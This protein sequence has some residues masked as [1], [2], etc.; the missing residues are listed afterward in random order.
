MKLSYEIVKCKIYTYIV[1]FFDKTKH[2]RKLK[3]F[4]DIHKGERCFI[5]GNGPSLTVD[6]LT[7]LH[8]NKE[9]T[10]ASNRIY[11]IFNKTEWRPTYYAS[12][13]R[14]I[15][16]NSQKE[17]EKI[18]CRAKF[19]PIVLHWYN[20][21]NIKDVY[22]YHHEHRIDDPSIDYEVSEDISK[23][24]LFKGTVTATMMQLA[25]YMG[26]TEIYLIGID[27]NY[28]ITKGNDGKFV[29]H[30]DVVDYFS[31]KYEVGIEKQLAHNLELS[32]KSYKDL[33]EYADENNIKVINATR[34]GK[35][36]VYPRKALEE[37]L[38]EE[39]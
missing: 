5:I 11:D 22:Y 21:I 7:L 37:I 25:F 36:E 24:I 34:G 8:T 17:I 3:K 23:N 30:K 13:D 20:D 4:K 28:R 16:E 29:E 32:T 35:L 10:F 33:K 1:E 12:E 31:N 9:I 15:V 39:K 14:I 38:S 19:I 2:G 27:H 18:N 26:F 6:D